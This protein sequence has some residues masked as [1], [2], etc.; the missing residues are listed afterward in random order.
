MPKKQTVLVALLRQPHMERPT[1]MRSDP[2]WEFGSFGLTGC[3]KTNLMHPKKVHEL[4]GARIAFVQGGDAGFKLVYLTPPVTPIPYSDRS[5]IR[6]ETS[7]KNGVSRE[8]GVSSETG[9]S[10]AT[11]LSVEAGEAGE[12]SETGVSN[13]TGSTMP[14]RYE[15]APFIISTSGVS[16][17]PEIVHIF[18]N[19]RRNGW[20]GRFASKFRTRR[21]PLPDACAAQLIKVW[22]ARVRKATAG[23]FA[24]IYTDALPYNPPK[25]DFDRQGTYDRMLAAALAG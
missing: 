11:G 10:G 15:K 1:E 20:M 23:D 2:F 25:T 5:E 14:F 24:R 22:N 16:D 9:V 19:V 13:E 17:V 21:E 7:G 8:T 12:S 18:E 3:H 4:K 6:W